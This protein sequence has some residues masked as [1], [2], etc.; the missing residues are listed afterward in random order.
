MY[1]AK[2]EGLKSD[3]AWVE[4][5]PDWNRALLIPVQAITASSSTTTTTSSSTPIALIHEMGMTSTRL[6]RGTSESPIKM[7][8]IYAKFND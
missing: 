7:K 8:V 3:P 4:K 2:Q 6:I 5:H 1:N